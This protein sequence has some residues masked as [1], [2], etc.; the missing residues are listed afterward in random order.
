MDMAKLTQELRNAFDILDVSPDADR[1]TVRTAWR[2][3]VRS[4][5]PDH[6]NENRAAANLHLAKV[7]AAY[8][9]IAAWLPEDVQVHP[10]IQGKKDKVS[11]PSVECGSNKTEVERCFAKDLSSKEIGCREEE[12]LR[13][14]WT[15][16]P[17]SDNPK[18]AFAR[19]K[20]LNA[21][22]ELAPQT[23]ARDFGAA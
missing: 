22:R 7:N 5:H 9:L 2:V 3:L 16:A 15:A 8:D 19:Y 17:K 6:Y 4:Y 20:I 10:A 14:S 12:S 21:V 1:I 11:S 23:G 18:A 13:A